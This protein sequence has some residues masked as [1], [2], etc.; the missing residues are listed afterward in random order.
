MS[1]QTDLNGTLL[2]VGVR[3]GDLDISGLLAKTLLY[4]TL[5]ALAKLLGTVPQLN[6][7]I[8]V[9]RRREVWSRE[10]RDHRQDDCGDRT[11]WSH[12]SDSSSPLISSGPGGCRM[13]MQTLPSL[14]TVRTQ[15]KENNNMKSVLSKKL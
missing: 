2:R 9:G 4:K 12:L 1:E 14:Y 3:V 7:G 11:R 15:G 13:L 6:R 10:K 5:N 8:D